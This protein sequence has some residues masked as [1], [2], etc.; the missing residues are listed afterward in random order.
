MR[1]TSEALAAELDATERII[2]ELEADDER[3]LQ[4]AEVGVTEEQRDRLVQIRTDRELHERRLAHLRR[5][6]VEVLGEELLAEAR[7]RF[8]ELAERQREAIARAEEALGPKRWAAIGRVQDGALTGL[9]DIQEAHR[10]RQERQA[11][12]EGFELWDEDPPIEQVPALEL[13]VRERLMELSRQI[14]DVFGA[15]DRTAALSCGR[16]PHRPSAEVSELLERREDL[17]ETE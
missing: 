13:G 10:A 12:R 4:A 5:R 15:C 2:A 17:L 1:T 7:T 16:V 14:D 3:A 11:L 6:R 8:T 9:E